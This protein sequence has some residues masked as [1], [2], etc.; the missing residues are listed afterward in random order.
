MAYRIVDATFVLDHLGKLPLV[1]VRTP[2]EFAAGHIPGAVNVDLFSVQP[3][4]TAAAVEMAKRVEA[5]GIGPN[6]ECIIYCQRGPRAIDACKLLEECGYTELD[7]YQA[8]F[9]D[10]VSNPTRPVER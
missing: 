10:W 4:G 5:L 6:D 9:S 7:C 2:A 1:D 3:A 8:S